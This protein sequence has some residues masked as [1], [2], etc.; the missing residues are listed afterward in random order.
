MEITGR[1]EFNTGNINIPNNNIILLQQR[2]TAK[3]N[4]RLQHQITIHTTQQNPGTVYLN[5][6]ERSAL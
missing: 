3:F 2:A 1:A 4:R 6:V 5:E